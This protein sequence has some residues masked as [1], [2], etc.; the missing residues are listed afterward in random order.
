M[1]EM[2]L[3]RNDNGKTVEAQIGDSIVIELPENPTTDTY[4]LDVKEATGI[5]HLADSLFFLFFKS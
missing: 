4:E 2:K 3:T 1:V 5:A